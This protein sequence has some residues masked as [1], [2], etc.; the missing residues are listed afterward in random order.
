MMVSLLCGKD[1]ISYFA[2]YYTFY[3]IDRAGPGRHNILKGTIATCSADCWMMHMPLT[4]GKESINV[5][6][7]SFSLSLSF[8]SSP[9]KVR[10]EQ[11]FINVG[12]PCLLWCV[13]IASKNFI[14]SRGVC[15]KRRKIPA[16][17]I[18]RLQVNG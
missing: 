9:C 13:E 16:S 5:L 18:S 15:H 3:C 4:L 6:A 11:L 1:L 8:P 2:H 10:H 12:L 7:A 14:C 17:Y